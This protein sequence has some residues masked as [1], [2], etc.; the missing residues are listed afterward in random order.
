MYQS[1]LNIIIITLIKQSIISRSPR[2]AA[3]WSAVQ[4]VDLL[5]TL[6]GAPASIRSSS[7]VNFNRFTAICSG[8]TPEMNKHSPLNKLFKNERTCGIAQTQI[9]LLLCS[10]RVF[11]RIENVF[12]NGVIVSVTQ[13][14]SNLN[15]FLYL[16]V[17]SFKKLLQQ[18]FNNYLIIAFV[19]ISLYN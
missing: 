2:S 19:Y 13:V 7:S 14:V 4:P 16:L 18:L 6:T 17:I 11:G 12:V 5:G 1:L 3:E 10:H 9:E 15:H 8:D